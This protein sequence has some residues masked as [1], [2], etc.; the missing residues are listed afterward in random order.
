[1]RPVV[2]LAIASL[3]A[4]CSGP[5]CRSQSECPFGTHCV[6]DVNR[7]TSIGGTCVSECIEHGDCPGSETNVSIPTCDNTGRCRL[8]ARPPT[9]RVLTPDVDAV[10]EEGTRTI[11][12]SGEVES[13]APFVGITVQ[14]NPSVSCGQSRVLNVTVENPNPGSF[15]V[16]PF[17]VDGV[18]VDTGPSEVVV[19]ASVL[20]ATQNKRI[21]IEIECVDCVRIDIDRTGT[22]LQPRDLE[23]PLLRGSISGDVRA[24]VWRVRAANGDVLDGVM[25]VANGG[26]AVSRLPLFAGTNRIEVSASEPGG[27]EARCSVAVEATANDRGLRAFISWDGPTSDLDLHVI[28]PGGSF[29]DGATSLSARGRYP[30]FGGTVFDDA[31]GFGPEVLRIMDPPLGIYGFIVEPV[32]NGMDPG[33][34]VFLRVLFD[35]RLVQRGP[36]GPAHVSADLGQLWVAGRLIVEEDGVTWDGH[37]Q[38]VPAAPLPDAPPE[39]WPPYQR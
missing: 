14:V 26:Y 6:L 39:Q 28:G 25:P 9:L 23:L 32:T 3:A 5:P 27:Q 11:V 37:D 29:G 4:S 20:G 35:G 17:I 2:I 18:P 31:E 15:A 24:A 16:V 8:T 13:A 34:S 10:Y 21:P 1:M 19:S 7:S 38:F 33:A 12:V 36:I 22:N 30:T